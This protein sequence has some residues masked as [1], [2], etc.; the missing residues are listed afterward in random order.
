MNEPIFSLNEAA[1]VIGVKPWVLEYLAKQKRIPILR[2]SFYGRRRY[3]TMAD[4]EK[5]KDYLRD[6][7]AGEEQ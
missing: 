2:K 4:I 3:W 1:D 6:T 7:Q 5:I